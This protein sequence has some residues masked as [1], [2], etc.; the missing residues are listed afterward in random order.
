LI[1]ACLRSGIGVEIVTTR[2]NYGKASKAQLVE[3]DR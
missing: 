3:S 2:K 1:R